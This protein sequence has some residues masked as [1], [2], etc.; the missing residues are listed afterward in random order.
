MGNF[1]PRICVGQ[2]FALVTWSYAIVRVVQAFGTV[3]SRDSEPWTEDVSVTV[4]SRNGA[5]VVFGV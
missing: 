4:G 2:Q 3:E 5:K 1:R